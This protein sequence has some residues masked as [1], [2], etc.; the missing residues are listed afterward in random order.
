MYVYVYSMIAVKSTGT[1]PGIHD[2]WTM[3]FVF[4]RTW[5]KRKNKVLLSWA[6]AVVLS[7]VSAIYH[8]AVT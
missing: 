1:V 6:T 7:C 5:G 8:R 4:V 2:I 3:L